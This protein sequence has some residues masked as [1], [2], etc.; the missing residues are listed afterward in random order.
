[1]LSHWLGRGAVV[2]QG[3]SSC[4]GTSRLGLISVVMKEVLSNVVE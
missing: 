2:E 3:D 1:M 4:Y